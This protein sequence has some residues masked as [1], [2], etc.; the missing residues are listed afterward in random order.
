MNRTLVPIQSQK[1]PEQDNFKYFD[2]LIS[3]DIEGER[4]KKER[5]RE[6]ERDRER[7]IE[8]DIER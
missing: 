1:F 6:R 3:T 4:E 7:E 8:R 2:I 5:E